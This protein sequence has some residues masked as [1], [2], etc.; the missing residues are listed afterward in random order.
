MSSIEKAT[1]SLDENVIQEIQKERTSLAGSKTKPKVPK[2][3]LVFILMYTTFQW[4][5]A[6]LFFEFPILFEDALIKKFGITPVEIGYF[7]GVTEIFAV[8]F[9]VKVGKMIDR[10]GQFKSNVAI[11]GLLLFSI[12][13][14]YFALVTN[15]FWLMCVSRSLYGLSFCSLFIVMSSLGSAWASSWITLFL[16]LTRAFANLTLTGFNYFLPIVYLR[17]DSLVPPLLLYSIVTTGSIAL[18]FVYLKVE[19]KYYKLVEEANK[20]EQ[21][22]NNEQSEIEEEEAEGVA[23]QLKDIKKIPL[24]SK[25]IGLSMAVFPFCHRIFRM[26][27]I[28]LIMIKFQKTYVEAKNAIALYPSVNMVL[29]LSFSVLF[30]A[31]GKKSFGMVIATIGYLTCYFILLLSSTGVPNWVVYGAFVVLGFAASCYRTCSWASLIMTLPKQASTVVVSFVVQMQAF[32]TIVLPIL[33]GILTKERTLEAYDNQIWMFIGLAGTL[34]VVFVWILFYDL[35]S[36]DGMLTKGDGHK[37]VKEYKERVTAEM[38]Q[39]LKGKQG[40]GQ[41]GD[42]MELQELGGDKTQKLNN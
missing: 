6:T 4:S 27:A 9:Q 18:S 2:F 33:V 36:C 14:A 38:E 20:P 23:F 34:F 26:T 40:P 39:Y 21:E 29:L 32:V 1:E 30:N 8:F 10:L 19:E 41:L 28:D 15:Q 35:T 42:V 37:D 12:V 31:I 5:S 3:V 25:V 22:E 13:L 7:M 11:Q 24:T 17:Y 16:G